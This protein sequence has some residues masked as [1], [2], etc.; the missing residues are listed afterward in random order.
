[1]VV[2]WPRPGR[3]KGESLFDRNAVAH[4]VAEQPRLALVDPHDLFATQTWVL[5]GHVRYYL[6]G[7]WERTGR[8]SADMHQ[9][10][11]RYP[12]IYPDE[13][14][15]MLILAGHHRSMAARVEGRSVLARVVGRSTTGPVAV[16]PSLAFDSVGD[17][18]DV[19]GTIEAVGERLVRAGLSVA[20]IDERTRF[21]GIG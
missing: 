2:P 9:R 15:R 1:M 6:T 17:A 20:E 14:G 8:T 13:R 5:R 3:R 21:A 12:L 10:A 16:T 11:N 7:E 4:F 18:N 19:A